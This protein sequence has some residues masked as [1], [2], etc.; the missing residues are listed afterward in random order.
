VFNH[1]LI[2]HRRLSQGVTPKST[3]NWHAAFSWQAFEALVLVRRLSITVKQTRLDVNVDICR[4]IYTGAIFRPLALQRL[5]T[6][7]LSRS[8]TWLNSYAY[9]EINSNGLYRKNGSAI[10][11][12]VRT[13][14]KID[15][16]MG[17]SCILEAPV[18]SSRILHGITMQWWKTFHGNFMI[19]PRLR[20][21]PCG[22][23]HRIIMEQDGSKP[24]YFL[25]FGNAS[26]F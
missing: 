6:D 24:C 14:M 5:A 7:V 12:G 21:I 2:S 18:G 23:H 11:L 19:I 13:S 3:L 10:E 16:A 8:R 15:K 1:V 17:R 4:S 26:S 9:S 25:H 22:I 20:G